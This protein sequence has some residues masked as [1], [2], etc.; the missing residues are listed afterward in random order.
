MVISYE[1]WHKKYFLLEKLGMSNRTA[2]CFGQE[3]SCESPHNNSRTLANYDSFQARSFLTHLALS[4]GIIALV[5]LTNTIGVI[6]GRI[7]IVGQTMIA[8]LSDPPQTKRHEG[9]RANG[10]RRPL[11]GKERASELKRTGW[12][13]SGKTTNAKWHA[14]FWSE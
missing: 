10:I 7:V 11:A 12:K 8:A 1:L 4:E 2:R 13:W 14:L 3:G 5:I 9:A 6:D